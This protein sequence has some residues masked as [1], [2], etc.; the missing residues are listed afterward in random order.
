MSF[1]RSV[2]ATSPATS[3]RAPAPKSTPFGF[4]SQTW[5]LLVRLPKIADGSLPTTRL[6]TLLAA[7]ACWKCTPWAAP[8]E[9]LCQFRIAPALFFTVICVPWV[10]T[11]AWPCTTC[12]PEGRPLCRPRAPVW[13]CSHGGVASSALSARAWASGVRRWRRTAVRARGRTTLRKVL[14][15]TV[16]SVLPAGGHGGP[17][18]GSQVQKA[19]LRAKCARTSPFFVVV[20]VLIARATSIRNCHCCQF[21]RSPRP[22]LPMWQ[23]RLSSR[24]G[25]PC[26][27]AT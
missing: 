6:S 3:T 1:S 4:S 2:L 19:V 13:A 27:L 7:P 15:M 20:A 25:S 9:K 26:W 22:R 11:L 23:W 12:R 10:A 24:Q 18:A 14:R 5:P 17:P 21:A 8:M 16:L